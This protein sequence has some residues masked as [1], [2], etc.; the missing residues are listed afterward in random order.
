MP[1]TE[2]QAMQFDDK[3]GRLTCVSSDFLDKQYP[4]SGHRII[5][6]MEMVKDSN[7]LTHCNGGVGTTYT[8]D[9]AGIECL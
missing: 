5:N 2:R 1:Q 6:V 7:Q 3:V 8:L 4:Y 9:E